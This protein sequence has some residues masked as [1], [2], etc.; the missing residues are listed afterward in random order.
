[1]TAAFAQ[2]GRSQKVQ[3]KPRPKSFALNSARG[4]NIRRYPIRPFCGLEKVDD[5][6]IFSEVSDNK[7]EEEANSD[8]CFL[9][10]LKEERNSAINVAILQ[11]CHI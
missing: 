2:S 7:T 4:A 3:E 11:K 1:M 6:S 10:S 9:F 8:L 5:R